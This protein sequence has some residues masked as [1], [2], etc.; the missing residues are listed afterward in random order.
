M[1]D[2]RRG[3]YHLLVDARRPFSNVDASQVLAKGVS[4]LDVIVM[5]DVQRLSD[6]E[7]TALDAFVERGGLLIATGKTGAMDGKGQPRTKQAM[8]SSPVEAF[9]DDRQG[10][11]WS[12][13]AREAPLKMTGGRIPVHPMFLSPIFLSFSSSCLCAALRK[14]AAAYAP[15]CRHSTRLTSIGRL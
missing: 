10:R 4:A 2:A 14:M 15:R 3:A 6:G 7:A 1:L 5:A 12:L 9:L 13:D 11:G 8:A